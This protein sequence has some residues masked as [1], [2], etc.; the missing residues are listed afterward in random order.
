MNQL[1]VAELLAEDALLAEL[2]SELEQARE[3]GIPDEILNA[4]TKVLKRTNM[5][6]LILAEMDKAEL[7]LYELQRDTSMISILPAGLWS[8]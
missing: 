2:R 7:A 4:E 5:R 8:G 6:N 3:S 1:I